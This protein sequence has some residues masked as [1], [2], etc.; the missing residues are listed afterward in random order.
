[1]LNLLPKEV[2]EKYHASTKAY[3]I[4]VIYLI[5]IAVLGLGAAGLATF[6]YMQQ[7]DIGNKQG[8]LQSL[9]SQ[10]QKGSDITKQ[11]AFLEDRLTASTRYQEK[12]DWSATLGTI[13]GDIPTDVQLT[14]LKLTDSSNLELSGQTT[15]QLSAILLKQRLTAEKNFSN[16]TMTALTETKGDKGLVYTFTI[17]FGSKTQ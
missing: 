11:A 17:T 4:S 13:A 16:V 6:N 12:A 10:Q 1:M 2:K 8:D 7:V 14:S 5:V 15:D 3:G 9:V